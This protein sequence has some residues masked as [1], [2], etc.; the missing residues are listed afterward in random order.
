MVHTSIGAASIVALLLA[1]TA[2]AQTQPAPTPPRFEA[3]IVVTPER[4]ETPR[5]LIPAST[6]VIDAETLATLPAAHASEITSSLPGFTVSRPQFHAGRPVVSARGFF[7]GGEAEYILLLVDGVPVADLESGLVDWSL[8]PVSSIRRVEAFRGPGASLYGDSAI[9]GVVQILTDRSDTVRTTAAAGSFGTFLADG[10]YGRRFDRAGFNVSGV[11]RRTDGGFDHSASQQV[12]GSGSTDGRI[13]AL[14]WRFHADGDTRSRDDPGSLTRDQHARDPYGSDP[15]FRF[16]TTDRQS[17]RAGFALRH[18]MPALRPQGRVYVSTRDEDSIR[19]IL[20]APNVGDRRARALE[21]TAVGGSVEGE[22]AFTNAR[23][24]VRF[25]LD[26]A[27]ERLDTSY[28]SVTPAGDP[29]ALNSA[30]SGRRLRAGTFVSSSWDASLRVR[31]YGALRLDSVD[32]SGFDRTGFD[33]AA[34]SEAQQRAWSPRAGVVIQ[35]SERGRVSLYAQASRAFKAPTMDQLFDPR[36]YPDFSGGTF[37]ISNS[38]LVP[39]R[40]TNIEAG[41]S[42][43]SRIRWSALA[44]HM[45]VDN[46]IDFDVRTFSYANIGRSTHSGFETEVD[47][48][49]ANRVRPSAS[50]ALSRVV[51]ADT[52]LQLKNVPR[53]AITLAADVALPWAMHSY[54][55][56]YRAW[57]AFLDDEHAFALEGASTIDVRVRRALARHTIFFDALNLA[58]HAYEEYGYT[59]V[60]FTGGTVPYIY[61]G[62]PR[63]LRAGI[64]LAF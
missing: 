42:G 31:L 1:N 15:T 12:L 45:D 6:V 41:I 49:I 23:A 28:R 53:H 48:R 4:G 61:A 58:G 59:L 37:T 64:T 46:E 54:V 33:D 34:A 39:Q 63:A 62:A 50:Y 44:Y 57:G 25:G 2:L 29:D 3:E 47:T 27:R 22:H 51:D 35:A 5:T 30:T 55:R 10:S 21:T 16:D 11:A 52:G 7:G 9:G 26:L 40:A 43:S 56:Y 19:T 18:D 8:V 20:L 32:D 60:D 13:N 36:P 24:V 14:S 17:F 38:A